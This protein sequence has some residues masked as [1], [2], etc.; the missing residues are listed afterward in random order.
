[1]ACRLLDGKK[2]AKKIACSLRR[3][4]V[5]LSASGKIKLVVLAIGG[6]P[7]SEVYI[8]AQRKLAASLGIEYHIKKY[9]ASVTQAELE[10][11]M[12]RLNRDD[13][14]TGIMV[15][16][17][18]PKTV[19]PE[20]L[21]QAIDPRKDAEGLNPAN[22]G[23]V[24]YE[25]WRVAPCTA[26]ACFYLIE[27]IGAKLEGKEVVIVGHSPVVG[28]PLALMLLSKLATVTVCHIGTYRR[29]LLE[30]HVK[31]AEIL[32]VAVGK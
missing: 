10:K 21:F 29:G 14:V 12:D 7:S 4:I 11:D 1:M 15:E 3:E 25:K 2:I 5:S 27:S 19:K 24:V 18:L 22:T 6:N 16:T 17:P 32:V 26:S 13:S 8:N 23:K 30:K 9:P 28:K 20:Q 31:R